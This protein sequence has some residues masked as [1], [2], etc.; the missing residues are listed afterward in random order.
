MEFREFKYIKTIA[1]LG[2]FTKAAAA[3]YVSQPSLSHLV[4]RTEAELGV[5]LFDRSTKPMSLTYAGEVYLRHAQEI[6]DSNEEMIRKIKDLSSDTQS[7]LVVGMPYERAAYMLPQVITMLHQEIPGL[8]LEVRTG[9]MSALMEMVQKGT[10]QFAIT[11]IFGEESWMDSVLIYEE[12]L[13]LA[14]AP[15]IIRSEDR[16]SG[17]NDVINIARLSGKPFVI[18][19]EGHII[20]DSIDLLF[21]EYEISPN[22]VMEVDGNSAA[23]R[24]STAGLG[25]CIVPRMTTH[26]TQAPGTHYLYR[27]SDRVPVTWEVRAVFRKGS[28]IGPVEKRFFEILRDA[29]RDDNYR[30]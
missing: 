30:I 8:Q 22:I 26:L 29:H 18:Q 28:P 24:M 17:K 9:S 21:R 1:E 3:L 15:N 25:A 19:R 16:L 12:E 11:P 23:F 10:V 2:S 6:L 13:C 20:R 27:L 4:A 14:A 5:T 7:K